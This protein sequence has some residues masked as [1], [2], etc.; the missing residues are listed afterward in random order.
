MKQLD[1]IINVALRKDISTFS[2]GDTVNVDVKIIEGGKEKLQG[3][4]GIV[5]ARRGRGLNETFMVRK[6]SYGEGVERI[7]YLNSPRI[8]KL[9]VIKRGRERRAK[10]YYLRERIGRRARVKELRKEVVAPA[11][12]QVEVEKTDTSTT[13]PR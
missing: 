3:F 10:L 5:L 13:E 9:E 6:I 4:K 8:N 11:K 2:V 12:D 1:N 7:F